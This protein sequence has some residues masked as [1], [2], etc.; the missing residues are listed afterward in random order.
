M[1]EFL[2]VMLVFGPV[3]QRVLVAHHLTNEVECRLMAERL[4]ENA[5]LAHRKE[6]FVCERDMGA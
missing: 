5:L 6:I 2:I 1:L 4:T 3:P